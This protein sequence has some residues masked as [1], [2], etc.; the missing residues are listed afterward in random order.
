MRGMEKQSSILRIDEN[1]LMFQNETH[2]DTLSQNGAQMVQ[3]KD[4]NLL[5]IIE[6]DYRLT[7]TY[8]P[9]PN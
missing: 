3:K 4:D 8:S 7:L 2:D 5:L 9:M 6:I 1:F